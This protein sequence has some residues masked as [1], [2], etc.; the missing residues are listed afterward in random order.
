[1]LASSAGRPASASSAQSNPAFVASRQERSRASI[2]NTRAGLDPTGT[3][4][5]RSSAI[6]GGITAHFGPWKGSGLPRPFIS[7]TNPGRM[8]DL[9]HPDEEHPDGNV[10]RVA[11]A[12]TIT[13][14]ATTQREIDAVPD[15]EV[16]DL[17]DINRMDTVGVWFVYFVV[18]DRGAK[19]IGV[20]FV[21]VC[22]FLL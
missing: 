3:N 20:C 21:V 16:I 17:S 7:R 11:G 19:V 14:A 13:R 8:A 9:N 22:L 6:A 15:P 1:M 4:R 12:L 10:Y 5:T 18:C 2:P